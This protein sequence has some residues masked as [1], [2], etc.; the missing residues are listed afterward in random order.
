MK[1]LWRFLTLTT[2]DLLG[3][4]FG[5]KGDSIIWVWPWRRGGRPKFI[6]FLL[7]GNGDFGD[8]RFHTLKEIGAALEGDVS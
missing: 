8:A 3:I 7:S 2:V 4:E 1:R 6:S 5:Y